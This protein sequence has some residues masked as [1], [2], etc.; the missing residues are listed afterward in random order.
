VR[1]LAAV[2]I[3][4]GC[5]RL[6]F[7][8]GSA[9]GDSDADRDTLLAGAFAHYAFDEGAGS[10]TRDI[11]GRNPDMAMNGVM[12]TTGVLAGGASADGVDDF[13][14]VSNLDLSATSAVTLSFWVARTY[15]SGPSRVLVELSG[16][17]NMTTTGFGVYPDNEGAACGGGLL[18]LF[19]LGDVG[20]NG[21]CYAPPSSGGWHHVVVVYDKSSPAAQEI[22]LYIDG[23]QQVPVSA[24]TMSD[25][26][27]RFGNDFF[28]VFSRGNPLG[29]WAAGTVD[30]LVVFDRALTPAEIATL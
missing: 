26:T 29:G 22:E 10:A 23:A 5:G 19:H 6:A 3:V 18:Y 16:N 12:W 30:D 1:R 4:C 8:H 25:N 7:D 2:L 28:Y 20:Y 13:M 14:F 9:D 27:N 17:A 15:T 24:P 21:R 11:T